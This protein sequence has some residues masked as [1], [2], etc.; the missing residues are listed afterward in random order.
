V[1]DADGGFADIDERK[2]ET[3]EQAAMNART[4]LSW[5]GVR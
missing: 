1:A 2:L 4:A 3:F 5:A